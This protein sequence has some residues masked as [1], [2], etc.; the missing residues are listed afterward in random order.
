MAVCANVSV[1]LCRPVASWGRG[2]VAESG[3]DLHAVRQPT[4]EAT[5]AGGRR[6]GG[7]GVQPPN[8][9][10]LDET[11]PTRTA[12]PNAAPQALGA[13]LFY[14]IA[15]LLR[16]PRDALALSALASAKGVPDGGAE[17]AV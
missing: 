1:C 9:D 8:R 17:V 7:G 4:C 14:A 12:A 11:P 15:G 3:A 13:D 5:K 6:A 2:G 16:E 10:V